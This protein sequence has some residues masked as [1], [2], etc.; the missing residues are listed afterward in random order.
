MGT[1]LQLNIVPLK[2]GCA[3]VVSDQRGATLPADSTGPDY[4]AIFRRPIRAGAVRGYDSDSGEQTDTPTSNLETIEGVA[5]QM[6]LM[7]GAQQKQFEQM[8]DLTRK[9]QS[10]YHQM[11]RTST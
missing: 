11:T 1:A 10:L 6:N 4:G 8:S 5:A 9:V 3:W 7:T 2:D